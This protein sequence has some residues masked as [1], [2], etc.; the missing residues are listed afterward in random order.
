MP[1]KPA[2]PRRDPTI[3]GSHV[4]RTLRDQPEDR[5]TSFS[6]ADCDKNRHQLWTWTPDEVLAFVEM[7][8]TIEQLPWQQ[9][10]RHRIRT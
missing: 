6:F 1:N 8:R 5:V 7:V 9:V 2:P 4:G 3:G 10:L